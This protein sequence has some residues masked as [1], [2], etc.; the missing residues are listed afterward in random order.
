[1]KNRRLF[2]ALAAVIVLAVACGQD[3]PPPPEP[4]GPTP[5]ELEQRRQDSIRAA[6]EAEEA[7]RRAAEAAEAERQRQ[8]EAQRA[9]AIREARATLEE[10]VYF[11]FDESDITPAAE[12]ILRSKVEILRSN[13][14]L[15]ISIQGHADER[16]STEYNLA[17]GTRRAEAVRQFLAG[18][19]L[20]ADRFAITSF[21]EER[22]AAMGS[23][24]SAWAQNRRAEFVITAGS[25]DPGM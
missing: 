10:T 22:P 13:P 15:R 18:F 9:E 21:G 19:G 8:L 14:S 25:I 1:M 11:D 2:P 12:R 3:P 20:G 7:A 4:T 24:E 23:T 6:R 16:G 17:L 5:E